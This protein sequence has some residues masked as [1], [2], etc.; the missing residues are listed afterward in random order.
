MLVPFRDGHREALER[1]YRAYVRSVDRYIRAMARATGH[2]EVGQP[3]AVADL[4]QDVFVRAFAPSARL[5]YDGLRDYG[6]YLI[7]IAKHCV[8]DALRARGREVLHADESAL[9]HLQ[10]HAESAEASLDPR[11]LAALTDY[12]RTLPANL[13]R[14]YELRFGQGESQEVVCLALACSRRSLRTM[15]GHLR[16]GLRKA[17]V[18]A[19]ISLRELG[20]SK[21]PAWEQRRL[22]ILGSPS[23]P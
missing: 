11:V 15:E 8:V 5:S 22:R 18:K 23:Q 6:A 1:V 17:L 10:E 7:T 9:T 4:I 14:V 3:S 12:I 20:A 19:G 21:A 13:A 16:A 2:A